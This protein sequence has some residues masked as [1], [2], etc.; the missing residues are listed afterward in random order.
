MND[1]IPTRKIT[2][3]IAMIFVVAPL[4]G[5]IAGALLNPVSTPDPKLATP[6]NAEFLAAIEQEREYSNDAFAEITEIIS[7]KRY[8]D[9]WYIVQAKSAS[10]PRDVTVPLLLSKFSTTEPIALAVHPGQT[11]P[12]RNMSSGRGVPY[13]VINEYDKAITSYAKAMGE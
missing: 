4:L 13:Q 12:Y 3:Y 6:S 1:T 7:V 5:W 8:N 9:W 11:L 2:F 10:T